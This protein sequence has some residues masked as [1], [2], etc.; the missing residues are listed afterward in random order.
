MNGSRYMIS[1]LVEDIREPRTQS[2]LYAIATQLYNEI[3]N[4]YFRSQGLWSAKGKTIL[5]LLRRTDEVFAG[6]FES[7]FESVFAHS[8]ADDVITLAEEVLAAQG[9]FLFEG[10]RLD[11]PQEW[12]TG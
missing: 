9:G 10:H 6:K 3:S 2:E 11:A 4:H 1:G 5:R 7:A 12:K 8:Q